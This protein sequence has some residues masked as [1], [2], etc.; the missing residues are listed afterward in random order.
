MALPESDATSG[1]RYDIRPVIQCP[2][3]VS[4]N[5]ALHETA[6]NSSRGY[7]FIYKHQRI[8]DHLLLVTHSQRILHK[9]TAALCLF[10]ILL[11]AVKQK[12]RRNLSCQSERHLIKAPTHHTDRTHRTT[13]EDTK[14]RITRV[15]SVFSVS[16]RP[17]SVNTPYQPAR[18]HRRSA[19]G[20]A[21]IA[22][23][24]AGLNPPV[25]ECFPR[26]ERRPGGRD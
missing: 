12:T 20:P 3:A 10:P 22:G 1:D 14:L 25:H 18:T 24:P 16:I 2:V 23:S 9:N 17:Q 15:C 7:L 11:S 5:T 19:V 13:K 6:I 21:G 26:T 8:P 4:K